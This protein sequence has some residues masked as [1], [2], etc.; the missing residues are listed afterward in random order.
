M[1]IDLLFLL[2]IIFFAIVGYIRGFINQVIS[3]LFILS[4]IFFAKPLGDWLKYSSGWKWFA[5]A[6]EIVAWGVTAFSFFLIWVGIH[7]LIRAIKKNPELSPPDR[8]IGLC[9]G[10]L[11]GSLVVLILGIIFQTLP[12]DSRA[13]FRDLD[14]DSKKSIFLSMSSGLLKWDGVS[15]FDSL[16][17]VQQRLNPREITNDLMDQAEEAILPEVQAP[18]QKKSERPVPWKHQN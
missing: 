7:A 14:R 3:I 11:K 12:E 1:Y 17:E 16:S 8:W 18:L 6:P 5:K 9:L 15:T 2:L 13:Q 10:F 4:V